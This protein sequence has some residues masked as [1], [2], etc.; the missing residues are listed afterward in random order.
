MRR[1]VLGSDK[2]REEKREERGKIPHEGE[3]PSAGYF[4]FKYP[5]DALFGRS[6]FPIG[7]DFCSQTPGSSQVY[8]KAA[9]IESGP[10]EGIVS[11]EVFQ[12]K[13]LADTGII[14]SSARRRKFGREL[15]LRSP[16]R[17]LLHKI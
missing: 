8:D 5:Q 15:F 1:C 13:Y 9:A 17:L 6:V 14:L 7:D 12:K 16:I 2:A 4:E 10:A 11:D 3:V